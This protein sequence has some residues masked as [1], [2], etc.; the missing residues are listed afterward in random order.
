MVH[1]STKQRRALAL[2]SRI[3]ELGIIGFG[4]LLVVAVTMHSPRFLS[5]DNFSE[6]ALDVA[7]LLIVAVGQMMVV[8]TGGIDLS[9]G[10]GLALSGMIVGMTY[11][12]GAAI[13]PI[14]ALL[15]GALIGLMLGS[16]NGV[17]V[18]KGKVPPIITTLGTMS[19]YRGMTF[20]ISRGAWVNAHEMPASFIGLAR[21]A[22]LG[23]PNLIL[24][25]ALV[26]VGFWFFMSH[27]KPGREIYAVGG[28]SEAARL[29]GIN[30]DRIKFMVYAVTGL[31]YGMSAVL[32]VSRY[33]SAQSDS[34]SGFELSTVAAVVIGGVSTF[35]GTGRITGV[36]FGAL[37]L[38]IIEN[39]LNVMQISPFWKLGIEGLVII[40]AVVLDEL[41]AR[42]VQQSIAR[43]RG[44][45][46]GDHREI[47]IQAL[48]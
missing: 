44:A 36:L 29:A 43:V 10:S 46:R 30:V 34:A 26:F 15:M 27:S 24:I 9:V 39:A 28:N 7:I 18:S 8:I 1:A 31:L 40:L 47:S 25:A 4:L 23:V 19:M 21:G 3:R 33:A 41:I 17:L 38:G 11:K 32:W 13:H 42:S 45:E 48:P 22:V 37:L 35:G 6:I 14:I 16:V 20:I 5:F 12:H 2:L